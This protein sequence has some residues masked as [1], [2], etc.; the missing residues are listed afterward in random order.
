[1]KNLQHNNPTIGVQ[2]FPLVDKASEDIYISNRS[3]FIRKGFCNF[4]ERKY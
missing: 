2:E 1:M 4:T 3:A